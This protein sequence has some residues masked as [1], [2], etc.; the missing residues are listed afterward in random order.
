[1]RKRGISLVEILI[2]SAVF[3]A[4]VIPLWG[5]MGSSH[6]Q[7]VRSADEIKASQLTVEI[8]EQIENSQNIE[9][10]PEDD[11]EKEFVLESGGEISIGGETPVVFKVGDFEEYMEPHLVLSAYSIKDGFIDE[12]VIGRVVTLVL[13]YKSK[14]GRESRYTLRGFISA[15][16]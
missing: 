15:N 1:M 2:A 5:L 8:L 4:A 14:E 9:F 3:L 6:Q 16:N 10:L 11:T 12:I 7:V 13:N